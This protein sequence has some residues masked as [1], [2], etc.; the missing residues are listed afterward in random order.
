MLAVFL[1]LI[2]LS[3]LQCL[4]I[5]ITSFHILR[6][7]FAKVEKWHHEAIKFLETGNLRYKII[8]FK[9][10]TSNLSID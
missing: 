10:T 3:N 1:I 6:L 5:H 7:N 4:D 9:I 2:N 8:V